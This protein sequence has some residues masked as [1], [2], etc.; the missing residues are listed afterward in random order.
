MKHHVTETDQQNFEI[1]KFIMLRFPHNV[2]VSVLLK[3]S[4]VH[5]RE[6]KKTGITLTS[7]KKIVRGFKYLG[8]SERT[9]REH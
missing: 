3:V 5:G 7:V 4:S 9:S 8:R 1:H 2:S 6:T